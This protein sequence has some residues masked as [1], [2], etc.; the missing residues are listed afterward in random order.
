MRKIL[1]VLAV[2]ALSVYAQPV[3][4][5][6][7]IAVDLNGAL[8]V[9]DNV[10]AVCD[11]TF[12]NAN[13][14]LN[15]VEEEATIT[16]GSASAGTD[17]TT[18]LNGSEVMGSL[19]DDHD[20]PLA[21]NYDTDDEDALAVAVDANLVGVI[22]FNGGVVSNMS[23]ALANSG[24]N[25]GGEESV[26][27]TGGASA[28]TGT[29]TD[30]NW[31][32][33][34]ISIEDTNGRGPVAYNEDGE[35]DGLAVAVDLNGVLVVNTNLGEVCNFSVADANSGMNVSGEESTIVTGL[36]E[37]DTTTETDLNS[38]TTKVAI[39]DSGATGPVAANVDFDECS[40]AV[41]VDANVAVVFNQNMGKVSNVS[42]AAAN[43]GMNLGGEESNI[44]TGGAVAGTTT[45]STVNS[46]TT[47]VTI[48]DRSNGPVAIN[49]EDCEVN[50]CNPE[51]PDPC[52]PECGDP[53]DTGCEV[54]CDAV[55]SCPTTGNSG[56]V[57]ANIETDGG[58]AVA[59]NANVAVV[60]NDNLA[61]VSNVS[62]ALANSGA[63]GTGEESTVSTGVA[64]ALT[65]TTNTVNTNSTDVSITDGTSSGPVAV[66]EETEGGVAV[67]VDANVA[68]VSN[69]NVAVVSNVSTAVANTGDNGGG[70]ANVG[71]TCTSGCTADGGSITTGNATADTTTTNN[72]NTNTTTFTINH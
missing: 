48:A 43:S 30:L 44:T 54:G 35:A 63:N 19:T 3:S 28:D 12:A 29:V 39:T 16:T 67:A 71:V 2:L 38:N 55:Q 72:V 52:E 8:I 40:T 49:T 6:E 20:G 37:A 53:C 17:A 66:N 60:T 70:A 42:L 24:F 14:G 68:V 18:S 31:N 64:T 51:I 69:D 22:N 50:P 62:V 13:T 5:Q 26:I 59:V 15:G 58:V 33:T 32:S 56:P 47:S 57:A 45:G 65:G 10:G 36:A 34:D 21:Y 27:N 61:G 23:F 7:A 11:F 4:A 9:N 46:N 1:I 41:G 25:Y